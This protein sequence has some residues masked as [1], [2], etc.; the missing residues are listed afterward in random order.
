M[1]LFY[2]AIL[3]N[4]QNN[5]VEKIVNCFLIPQIIFVL[6]PSDSG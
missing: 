3:Q 1:K 2:G 4:I 5:F 6:V